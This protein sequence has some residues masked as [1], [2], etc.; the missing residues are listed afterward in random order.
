MLPEVLLWNV[1]SLT[2]DVGDINFGGSYGTHDD[3]NPCQTNH[4]VPLSERC[5][6]SGSELT[7]NGGRRLACAGV[8]NRPD[9]AEV[10]GSSPLR[11]TPRAPSQQ[12]F[13]ACD[14]QLRSDLLVNL[15]VYGPC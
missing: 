14:P 15:L 6:L 5:A 10:S 7:A 1:M 12:Q 11:P 3:G 8:L 9:K 4:R 2:T 13:H